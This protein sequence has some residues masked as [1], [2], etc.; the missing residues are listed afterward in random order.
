MRCLHGIEAYRAFVTVSHKLLRDDANY[1]RSTYCVVGKK[2][3]KKQKQLKKEVGL[4]TTT[5]KKLGEIVFNI[6]MKKHGHVF[7][8]YLLASLSEPAH[9][10]R[11]SAVLLNIKGVKYRDFFV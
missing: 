10:L 3:K 9:Y 2:N 11:G 4:S 5:K 6:E 8:V 1:R 7:L